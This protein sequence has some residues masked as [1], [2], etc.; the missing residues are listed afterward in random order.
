MTRF[1]PRSGVKDFEQ[2]NSAQSSKETLLTKQLVCMLGAIFI[3]YDHIIFV[4]D[5]VHLFTGWSDI[6]KD[7]PKAFHF[8][9]HFAYSFLDEVKNWLA[10]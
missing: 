2:N 9:E 5:K 3:L 6:P 4:A 1:H 8:L 7:K 10:F